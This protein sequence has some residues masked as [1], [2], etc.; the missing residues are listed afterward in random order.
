M[1]LI[2]YKIY[3][4]DLKGKWQTSKLLIMVMH[5]QARNSTKIIA[6]PRRLKIL[7]LTLKKGRKILE[8][9]LIVSKKSSSGPSS[10]Q[11]CSALKKAESQGFC[12]YRQKTGNGQELD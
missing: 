6:E 3:L 10:E 2:K 8:F 9:M 12:T 11:R 1:E 4:A 5:Q 7:T